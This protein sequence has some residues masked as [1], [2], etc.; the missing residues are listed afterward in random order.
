MQE[1]LQNFRYLVSIF[2]SETLRSRRTSVR[3]AADI[4]KRV[5]DILPNFSSESQVLNSLWDIEKDFH[6]IGQL[7]QALHFGYNP[8]EI[9]VYE[10]E[11]KEYA[12][13]IFK[14]N[15]AQSVQFLQDAAQAQTS[16]QELCIRYPEFCEYLMK[17]SEKAEM[18]GQL[19][20]EF[21]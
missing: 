20:P 17:H 11:I 12:A 1:V 14:R 4:A 19:K 7:R 21:A 13:E 2:F 18:L 9:K 10:K 16:I 5:A 8:S 15:M 6:E 3:R